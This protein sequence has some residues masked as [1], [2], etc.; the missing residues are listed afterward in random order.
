MPSCGRLPVSLRRGG[1][2]APSDD[3]LK[4]LLTMQ[5][6]VAL[7]VRDI[8]PGAQDH[9]D[10]VAQ[11]VVQRRM[12]LARQ[13]GI[14]GKL[15]VA[16]AMVL[17]LHRPVPAIGPHR[18]HAVDRFAT[19][20]PP[21][22]VLPLALDA[23]DLLQMRVVHA[24]G[25]GAQDSDAALLEEPVALV[26][27][28]RIAAG[29]GLLPVDWAEGLKRPLRIGLDRQQGVSAVRVDQCPGGSRTV[30]RT[31]RVT[32]RPARGT[33]SNRARTAAIAPFWSCKP[34]LARGK[35]EP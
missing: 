16:D 23:E 11:R 3:S 32:T 10:A 24:A 33:S 5:A 20:T 31:S 35:S 13:T 8:L 1:A 26:G 28:L 29:A 18:G 2:E 25:R 12:G 30:C 22:E 7:A 14:L 9:R 17:I 6:E 4:G 15:H 34:R 27:L 21:G 19:D